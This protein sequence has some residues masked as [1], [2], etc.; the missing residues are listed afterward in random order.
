MEVLQTILMVIGAITMLWL[1]V[2]FA[3]CLWFLGKSL[4]NKYLE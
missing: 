4:L 1:V 2:K 3:K